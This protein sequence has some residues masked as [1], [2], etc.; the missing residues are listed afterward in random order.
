MMK[1]LVLFICISVMVSY[2][3]SQEP[4]TQQTI[5]DL[6]ESGG[7]AMSDDTDI[8]EILEDL[9]HFRQNP[10]K[11]NVAN[12]KEFLKLHLLSELEINNLIA[13]R[14]KTGTIYSLYE[15]ASIDGFTPDI[16]EKIEPFI[17]FEIQENNNRRKRVVN[18]LFV[19]ST[20]SFSSSA[21]DQSKYEGSPE[22]YY[23]RIKHVSANIEYGMVN[24]KDPGEAFFRKSN[25]QGFDYTSAFLNFKI[26]QAGNRIYVGD[27]HVRFGQGLVAWQGFSMGKSAEATQVLRSNQGIRSYS[28]TDENQFFR[29]F[30][31]QVKSGNF[32]F[33]PFLSRNRIDAHL[34]TLNGEAFFGAFQTSGYHR[35]ESEIAGENSLRQLVGGANMVYSY[36]RWSFGLTTV[37]TH[38]DAKLDRSGEPYNLF[39]PDGKESIVTGFDW[40][41]SIKKVFFF[42]EAAISKNSGK[43]FLAGIMTKPAS[44]A[45]FS[46]V[47]RNINRTYSSF[48]SNAFTESS[49]INDEHGMYL[50]VKVLPASRWM[51]Q[52]Y[53]DFFRHKWIKYTT[54]APARG[55]EFSVQVSYNPSRESGFY[56]KFFQEGKEQRLIATNLKYNEL[57]LINR[58]RLNFTH[59]V[60]EQISIKSRIESSFYSK[61]IKEKGYLIY[62]DVIFKP[63][64]KS[65]S[66]NGRLAYFST[67]GYNS[68]LY[69]YENDVLYS[70]SVPALYGKG[71]RSYFNFQQKLGLKLTLWLKLS[72]TY[73]FAQVVENN[74]VD[75]SSKTEIKI[76][77][78]YQF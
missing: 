11:V 30:A 12:S 55:T 67:D 32:T 50:G 45:E 51:I 23:S 36:D 8:Q 5:E 40:K 20:R 54:A 61:I 35:A 68:R 6:L 7:E 73:Q 46:M 47:Y 43:A 53:A 62:Q 10:L 28:S 58:L 34:D 48:F 77:M 27:Y 15:M 26:D 65:F 74:K 25:K 63:A 75:S 60:N 78:R 13:F 57:Q 70:F 14:K 31:A 59:D 37:Y 4:A 2:T 72:E 38:F 21:S 22:R 18:D 49:R 9:E 66:M 76:Q 52:A 71:L 16:L 64:G 39:L 41:G 29:G 33:S 56:L 19:R 42:G 3:Y 1:K 24:E 69:A 44:N 17:S